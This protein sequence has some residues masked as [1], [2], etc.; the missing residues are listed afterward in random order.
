MLKNVLKAEWYCNYAQKLDTNRQYADILCKY[1]M[2]IARI[3]E[4]SE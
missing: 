3:K 1:A 4:A 2:E